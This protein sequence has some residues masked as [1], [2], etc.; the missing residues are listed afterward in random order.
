MAKIL[1]NKE[2][3]E[4]YKSETKIIADFYKVCDNI[5][6]HNLTCIINPTKIDNR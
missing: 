4:A 1:S 2:L 5:G 6:S 3:I